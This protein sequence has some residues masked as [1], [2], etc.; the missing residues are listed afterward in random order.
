MISLDI[1]IISLLFSFFFGFL[2][3]LFL[4]INRTIIYN[5]IK[6]IK[7]AGSFLIV[8]ISFTFYFYFLQI[9]DN[10]FFHIYHLFMIIFGFI[11][12]IKIVKFKKK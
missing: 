1:Q 9:I 10:S 12:F 11:S 5:K 7:F 8:F 4:T 3:S 6:V 2:F